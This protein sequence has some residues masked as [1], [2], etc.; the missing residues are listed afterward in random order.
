MNLNILVLNI[1]YSVLFGTLSLDLLFNFTIQPVKN[2]KQLML[3]IK[4]Y[5]FAQQIM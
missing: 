1:G 3:S 5:T 2:S 4:L